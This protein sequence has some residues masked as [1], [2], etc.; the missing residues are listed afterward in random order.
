M[1]L[2]T[3]ANRYPERY[4]IKFQCKSWSILGDMLICNKIGPYLLQFAA[5]RWFAIREPLKSWKRRSKC[6]CIP[7]FTYF[8]RS[9][10][11]KPYWTPLLPPLL[12]PLTLPLPLPL[13]L[14]SSS[15]NSYPIHQFGSCWHPSSFTIFSKWCKTLR[16]VKM[17][18]R[19]SCKNVVNSA[20]CEKCILWIVHTVNSAYCE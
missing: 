4:H 8:A 7:S 5:T 16:S 18:V 11:S 10:A 2:Y 12:L 9:E 20:Y 14:S 13:P 1:K 19:N 3:E 17:K 15:I 6:T